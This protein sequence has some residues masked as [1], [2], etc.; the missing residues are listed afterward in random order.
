MKIKM[1]HELCNTL[2][3]SMQN[4]IENQSLNKGSSTY[5]IITFLVIFDTPLP[6]IINHHHFDNPYPP[7]ISNYQQF[8]IPSLRSTSAQTWPCPIG[9]V[10]ITFKFYILQ[11]GDFFFKSTCIFS[12]LY[13]FSSDD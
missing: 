5:Y 3:I 6:H 7:H 10:R 11:F 13:F 4:I 8:N 1:M 2:S 12:A 9:N